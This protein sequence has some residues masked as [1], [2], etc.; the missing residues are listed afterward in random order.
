MIHSCC[1]SSWS[2][3]FPV[4]S[5]QKEWPLP[6]FR[7]QSVLQCIHPCLHQKPFY[8]SALERAELS[9]C[10]NEVNT[11][12]LLIRAFYHKKT[13]PNRQCISFHATGYHFTG[14]VALRHRLSPALLIIS[15]YLWKNIDFIILSCSTVH[16]K[17][18]TL[19]TLEKKEQP[20]PMFELF[21]L[22]NPT[23]VNWS[24]WFLFLMHH[25]ED[26]KF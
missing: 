24:T 22:S 4:Y 1:W 10:T 13:L 20:I 3:R 23:M 6:A 7:Y 16:K 5:I 26:I 18:I 12:V 17:N 8:I 21:F 25:L 14:P 2:V 11:S 9:A 19:L 15:L